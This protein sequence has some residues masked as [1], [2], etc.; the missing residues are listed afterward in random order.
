M[1]DETE[2]ALDWGKFGEND[3]SAST[4]SR[5]VAIYTGPRFALTDPGPSASL[6]QRLGLNIDLRFDHRL[7]LKRKGKAPGVVS[8]EGG[9]DRL[10]RRVGYAAEHQT[11]D[12]VFDRRAY[13]GLDDPEA[14]RALGD[15]PDARRLILDLLDAGV[16]RIEVGANGVRARLDHVPSPAMD[17]GRALSHVAL[18]L[19]TLIRRWPKASRNDG[20]VHRLIRFDRRAWGLTWAGCWIAAVLATALFAEEADV[21]Q[22]ETFAHVDWAGLGA[23]F[24]VIV[25]PAALLFARHAVAHRLLAGVLLAALAVLPFSYRLRVVEANRGPAWEPGLMPAQM[26]ALTRNPYAPGYLAFA[27]VAGRPTEWALSEGEG[28]LAREGRLCAAGLTARGRR[29]LRYVTGLRTWTCRPGE[30]ARRV[31]LEP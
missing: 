18:R 21:R 5:A 20:P 12:P 15:R 19:D 6:N 24:A 29:G 2:T 13:L 26:A 23:M 1:L 27:T 25:A 28:D 30:P 8:R 9:L 3:W 11:G 4:P 16:T 31:Q 7:S 10:A 22:I 14:A 17:G